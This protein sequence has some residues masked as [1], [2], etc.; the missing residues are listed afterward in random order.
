MVP[1]VFFLSLVM[2]CWLMFSLDFVADV[3]VL[4]VVD[5]WLIVVATNTLMPGFFFQ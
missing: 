4:V 1:V 3:N 2:V 5:L